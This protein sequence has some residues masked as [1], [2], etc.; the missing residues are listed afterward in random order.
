VDSGDPVFGNTIQRPL[1]NGII[2]FG[3]M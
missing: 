2:A 1:R 3:F